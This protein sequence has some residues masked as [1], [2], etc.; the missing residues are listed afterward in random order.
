MVAGDTLFCFWSVKFSK[1]FSLCDFNRESRWER[2]V[3]QNL[4]LRYQA[5]MLLG[6]IPQKLK[7]DRKNIVSLRPTRIS[8]VV[9][10]LNSENVIYKKK[11]TV[12]SNF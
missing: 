10:Y 11:S 5:V 6:R 4:E 7:P 8:R 2:A 12:K 9:C 3:V 1:A